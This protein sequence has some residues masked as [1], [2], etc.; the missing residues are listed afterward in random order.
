VRHPQSKEFATTMRCAAA[1]NECGGFVFVEDDQSLQGAM[2]PCPCRKLFAAGVSPIDWWPCG[3]GM[4][5]VRSASPLIRAALSRGI[6]YLRLLSAPSLPD[7]CATAAAAVLWHP[8]L[9][10]VWSVGDLYGANRPILSAGQLEVIRRQNEIRVSAGARKSEYHHLMSASE[11]REQGVE[12][13]RH[14]SRLGVVIVHDDEFAYLSKSTTR[15]AHFCALIQRME[16]QSM[17]LIVVTSVD[18]QLDVG[19]SPSIAGEAATERQ[20]F[21]DSQQKLRFRSS[22]LAERTKSHLGFADI[23]HPDDYDRFLDRLMAGAELLNAS[24]GAD[25]GGHGVHAE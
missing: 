5:S 21:R 19:R 16:T 23:M 1:G 24:T 13:L 3:L 25:S 22:K 7:L 10:Q 17:P 15:L 14:P 11:I 8:E 6:G 9:R 2:L 18:L 12:F 20:S 4:D